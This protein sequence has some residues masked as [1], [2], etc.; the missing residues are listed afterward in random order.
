MQR[1]VY[2]NISKYIYTNMK[3]NKY[4]EIYAEKYLCENIKE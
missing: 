1:N 4:T 2:K 3:I